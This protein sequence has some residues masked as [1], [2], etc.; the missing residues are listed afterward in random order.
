MEYAPLLG[1]GL[2]L[3]YLFGE[4]R[5][6]H[7]L[8]G[9][10]RLVNGVEKHFR[11]LAGNGPWGQMVAG[12]VAVFLLLTLV[13]LPVWWLKEDFFPLL[14][15]FCLYFAVGGKS[16]AEH[17]KQVAEALERGDLPAARQAVAMLV[18]RDVDS[19]DEAGVARAATES[20]LENGCDAVFAALFWFLLLGA[21]GV[22]MYRCANTLDAMWGY[23]TERYLYFGRVAARLD[24]VL[25][26]LPARLTALTYA[27]QGNTL[28][29]MRCWWKQGRQW[30]SPNAGPVMAAGAG[31]LEISLGG[32][33]VY[34]G[35]LRQRPLLG[36]GR[37]A[38]AADILAAVALVKWGSWWWA[39][40]TFFVWGVVNV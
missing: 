4:V 5:R 25:N 7:P 33:A 2:L 35:Q 6:F 36:E 15:V 8:V 28:A 39:G 38:M 10:G 21:P 12:G 30:Y 11:R 26:Y 34:H 37:P 13:V 16:L 14:E 18:S 24:D 17:G 27:M 32:E 22:V 1:V 40:M 29:S 31:A 20:V 23:K 19:L 3:D 9:F